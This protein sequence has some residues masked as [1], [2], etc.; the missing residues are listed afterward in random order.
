MRARIVALWIAAS[1]PACAADDTHEAAP[2]EDAQGDGAA[3]DT[4]TA[5]TTAAADAAD[6]A[7]V[8]LDGTPDAAPDAEVDAG[9]DTAT[10]T[11]T[12]TATDTA[13]DTTIDTAIDTGTDGATDT[14]ADTA[15][16]TA[17]ADAG[18][19]GSA[20]VH[21][22][23]S[24][25]CKVSTS[26]SAFDVP[27]GKTLKIDWHNHSA[28]Y[29][30]D[31]WASYGGGYLELA[32]GATWSEKYEHC[33]IKSTHLEWVDVS[34]AGSPSACGKVRVNIQCHAP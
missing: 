16:D 8:A 25:T 2:V 18:W 34:P 1:L 22:S 24:N 5:D 30:A 3:V 32:K 20:H 29:E 7:D 14:G 12:D 17:P 27:A 10:D 28:D 19:T 33:F 13:T 6:A 15:T 4:S 11:T 26:P 23:I 21:I 9:A 31:V